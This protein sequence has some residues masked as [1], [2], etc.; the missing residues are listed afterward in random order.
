MDFLQRLFLE[1]PLYLAA[2]SFLLLAAV[3]FAR[4]WLTGA[5]ARWSLPA[6][7]GLI[8]ILFIVQQTVVTER[9][10]I[11]ATLDEFVAAI[12]AQDMNG[13][14]TT[15]GEGYDS[16]NMDREM[17]IEFIRTSLESINVYDTRFSRRDVT[18]D[19]DRADMIIV[20]WATVR[21]RGG[22]GEYHQGQ[23]RIAWVREGGE[24]KITA[25]R[26]LVIDTAPITGMY[27]LR[28]YRY[29][30]RLNTNAAQGRWRDAHGA[31]SSPLVRIT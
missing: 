28:P 14:A 7:L 29:K 18:V 6:V 16:D 20:A 3:L 21:I 26:P 31:R 12:A 22:A 17:I 25:L 8:A 11:Q 23:W 2:F 27:Q 30:G 15:I 24:W 13:V 1:S 4:R 5:A 10:R 9:K 19:G